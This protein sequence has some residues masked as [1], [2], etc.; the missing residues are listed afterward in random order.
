MLRKANWDKTLKKSLKFSY[1]RKSIR[2]QI[3]PSCRKNLSTSFCVCL[4]SWKQWNLEIR[5]NIAKSC[6]RPVV[7]LLYASKSALA[8]TAPNLCW[9]CALASP[10]TFLIGDHVMQIGFGQI[11]PS[12][13][14]SRDL[15]TRIS[16]FILSISKIV[17]SSF[18]TLTRETTVTLNLYG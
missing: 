13:S 12:A 15:G 6:H 16:R 7:S 8:F 5:A 14:S 10:V 11:S 17:K 4:V 3:R 1:R 2:K 18:A 9:S